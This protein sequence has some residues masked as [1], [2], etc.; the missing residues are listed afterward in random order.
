MRQNLPAYIFYY[1]K[2]Y[3]LEIW[4]VVERNATPPLP[5]LTINNISVVAFHCRFPAIIAFLITDVIILSRVTG[6]FVT[7]VSPVHFNVSFFR[8][9]TSPHPSL[10]FHSY[11]FFPLK[12]KKGRVKNSGIQLEKNIFFP[13][14]PFCILP[15][16][17]SLYSVFFMFIIWKHL[18]IFMT[19]LFS[20]PVQKMAI[21]FPSREF[22]VRCKERIS[23][24]Y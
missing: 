7:S 24:V 3:H 23:H 2:Y 19:P 17:I 20:F 22:K 18:F 4:F 16:I 11:E 8:L 1:H 6:P 5:Q 15:Q 21:I 9:Y 10:H 13:S 14:P 12:K